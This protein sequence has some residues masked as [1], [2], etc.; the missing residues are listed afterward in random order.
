LR[1]VPP[2]RQFSLSVDWKGEW[3]PDSSLDLS[4]TDSIQDLIINISDPDSSV[5]IFSAFR[6]LGG[7][8]T[9]VVVDLNKIILNIDPLKKTKGLDTLTISVTDKAGHS[10]SVKF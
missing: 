8:S 5:E 6:T 9:A 3:T 10:D 7:E 2:N 1:V 4:R